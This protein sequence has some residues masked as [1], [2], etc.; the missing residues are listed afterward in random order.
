MEDRRDR[1][2]ITRQASADYNDPRGSGAARRRLYNGATAAA[3]ASFCPL[4]ASGHDEYFRQHRRHDDRSSSSTANNQL[5]EATPEPITYLH[6]GHSG[7]FPKVEE[8]L[9]FKK[10]GDSISVDPRAR[11]RVRRIR[12][13]SWCSIEPVTDLPPDVEVGMQFEATYVAEQDRRRRSSAA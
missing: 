11:G 9:N 5:L 7:I 10:V 13:P 6:G 2:S 1:R 3:R 4:P 12:S 8:A